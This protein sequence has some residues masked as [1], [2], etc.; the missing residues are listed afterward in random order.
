[1]RRWYHIEVKNHHY[2][3]I[4]LDCVAYLESSKNVSTGDEKLFTPV[5]FKWQGV[6]VP[7]TIIPP[8][9]TRGLDAFF[10]PHEAPNRVYF[11]INR[12]L[13]DFTGLYEE[14]SLNGPG[15]FELNFV[16]YSINFFPIRSTFLLHIGSSLDDIKFYKKF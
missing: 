13:V 14:Y 8:R 10:V 4:A 3:K 1:M 11:G 7:R 2:K 6:N 9:Y 15:K 12:S 5:E 16:V